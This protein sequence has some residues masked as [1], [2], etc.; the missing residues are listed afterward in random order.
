MNKKTIIILIIV[1]L[2]I[3]LLLTL[4]N[5]KQKNTGEPIASSG[6]TEIP[7]LPNGHQR[8]ALHFHPI[9]KIAVD[10]ANEVVPGNIGIEGTCMREI[11]THDA[12]GTI[13]VE[14]AKMGVTYTLADFFS[15]WNQKITR[16]GYT[17]QIIQ[18]GQ[19]KESAKDVVLFDASE[20]ELQ[21]ISL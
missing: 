11:H 13:H 16:D 3:V 10:G 6:A 17:F 19:V 7:C 20:I 5:K 2:A 9:L 4:G 14:T 18:D 15:A 8:V 12:T 21:Y 1:I